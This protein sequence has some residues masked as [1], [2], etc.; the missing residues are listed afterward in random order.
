MTDSGR[1]RPGGD[2]T[3]GSE[4]HVGTPPERGARMDV[5]GEP[6]LPSPPRTS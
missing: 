6:R 3:K 5:A 1:R 4:R 2:R